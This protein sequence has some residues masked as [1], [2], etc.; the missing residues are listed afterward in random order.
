MDE[1]TSS[2][3]SLEPKEDARKKVHALTA[4]RAIKNLLNLCS[5][6]ECKEYK[7]MFIHYLSEMED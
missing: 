4:V 1:I 7:N 6:S 5:P 2:L 3:L